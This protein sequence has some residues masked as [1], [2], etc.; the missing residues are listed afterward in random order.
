M[1]NGLIGDFMTGVAENCDIPP[2]IRARID[3]PADL[4]PDVEVA[5]VRATFGEPA[6]IGHAAQMDFLGLEPIIDAVAL[7]AAVLFP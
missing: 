1:H 2:S 3:F 5:T 4:E 7:R 6:I